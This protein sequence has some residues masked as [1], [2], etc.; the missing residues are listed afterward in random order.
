MATEII[1]ERIPIANVRD[2]IDAVIIQARKT[3]RPIVVTEDGGETVIIIDAAQ[4]H[5]VREERELIRAI[6][7]G[8]D[9]IR[10]GKVVSMEEVEARLDAILAEG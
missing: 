2:N 7:E 3:K 9:A 8:E 1:E 10:A 5:K 6:L 4:Y